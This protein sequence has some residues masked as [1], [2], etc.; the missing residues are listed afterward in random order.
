V[1]AER[2]PMVEKFVRAYRHGAADYATMVQLD[3][4]GKRISTVKTREIATVIARYAFPGRALGR[5]AATVES[6]AFPMD[7][8]AKLDTADIGRQV[9]W[10]KAQKLIEPDV[11]PQA[12]VDTGFAVGGH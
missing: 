8:Q 3:R 1:L 2:R 7:P 9:A 12:I 6:G 11:D 4:Y 10:F 5:A